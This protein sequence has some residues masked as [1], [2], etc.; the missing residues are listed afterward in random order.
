MKFEQQQDTNP[1]SSIISLHLSQLPSSKA[2]KKNSTDRS[3][4]SQGRWTKSEH[5]KFV[6]GLKIFGKNWKKVQEFVGTRN[7]TQI[8]SHA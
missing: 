6:E 3:D 2:I 4:G 1:S 8:R 7:G 5:Q